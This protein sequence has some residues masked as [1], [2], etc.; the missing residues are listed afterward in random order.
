LF[1][2]PPVSSRFQPAVAAAR[3]AKILAKLVKFSPL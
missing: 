1:P 2:W 3:A